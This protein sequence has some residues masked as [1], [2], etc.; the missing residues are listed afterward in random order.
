VRVTHHCNHLQHPSGARCAGRPAR[1]SRCAGSCHR[2]LRLRTAPCTLNK[3][4]NTYE[5]LRIAISF[6]VRDRVDATRGTAQSTARCAHIAC[7]PRMKATSV[8]VPIEDPVGGS[9]HGYP[10]AESR[11][12]LPR[13]PESHQFKIAAHQMACWVHERLQDLAHLALCVMLLQHCVF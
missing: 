13:L 11:P 2:T 8:L 3:K 4:E 7:G 6:R 1:P 5:E 10:S 12:W 9:I